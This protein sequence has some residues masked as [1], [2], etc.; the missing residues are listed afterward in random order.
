MTHHFILTTTHKSTNYEKNVEIVTM[1]FYLLFFSAFFL[2]TAVFFLRL[3][4]SVGAVVLV[5]LVRPC[6]RIKKG[7]NGKSTCL[8]RFY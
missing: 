3:F 4:C 2:L 1:G 5:A 8:L 6:K 7:A